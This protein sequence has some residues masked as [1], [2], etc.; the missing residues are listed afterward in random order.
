[1]QSKSCRSS[2]GIAFRYHID[3]VPSLLSWLDLGTSLAPGCESLNPDHP[4]INKPAVS[5]VV[6]VYN[7]EHSLAALVSRLG[8]TL[9]ESA[10]SHEILLVDDGS[11][12]RSWRAITELV[13]GNDAVRGIRL[14]RNYG[15]HSA[16]L[17]GINQARYEVIVTLDDDLQNPPE[18]IPK[19]L[20]KLQEGWDVVYGT[21]EKQQH[22]LWRYV[23]SQATK[24]TLQEAMG[25]EAAR[26]ISSFRAFRSN[27]RP[28]FADYHS[29]FVLIDVLLT[30]GTVKFGTVRVRHDRREVGQSNYTVSTLIRHAMNLTTGFSTL[31]LRLASAVGFGVTL[32]GVGVLVYVLARYLLAGTSVAGFTF[33]ASIIAIFSGGQLFTLGIIGEYL[34]RMHVRMMNRPAYVIGERLDSP[35]VRD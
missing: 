17:A 10:S 31:P 1:M 20:D 9:A 6:P 33:L 28:A 12:D 15:Q 11:R 5:V 18:E 4:L 26:S 30:W 29:P 23:A 3:R 27:L 7:S 25:A 8:S 22:G 14:L 24:F 34:A 16:L 2:G 35:I 13:A 32:F 21:P 19:L